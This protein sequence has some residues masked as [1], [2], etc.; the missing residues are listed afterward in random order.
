MQTLDQA[1]MAGVLAKEIDPDDAY[2]YANDR[3]QFQRY[4]T[5]TSMLPKNEL[6]E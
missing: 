2:I 1:L 4:V 3:K 6:A 5:D